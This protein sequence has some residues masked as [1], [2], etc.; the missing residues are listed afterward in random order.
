MSYG[1]PPSTETNAILAKSLVIKKYGLKEDDR[2][3][4]D[5]AIHR[6][7][8]CNEIS[9][10]TVN[11]PP[12]E[13]KSIFVLRVEL[14]K[15]ECSLSILRMLFNLIDQK[16]II[17]LEYGVMCRPVTFHDV[18]IGGGWRPL[19]DFSLTLNGLDLD[20]VWANLVIQIGR[21][22]VA[23]GNT[24]SEQILIDEKTRARDEKIAQLRK[25]M[26]SEKQP[27]KKRELFEKI[28]KLE[29]EE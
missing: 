6:I 23:E 27:R 29:N 10:S 14:R 11:I 18:L 16:M 12:G 7:T 1:L 17:V 13:I 15:E 3:G 20:G 25:K 9:P 24:L 2:N 5:A 22:E 28:R 8:I 19:S 4:F 21:I 26:M